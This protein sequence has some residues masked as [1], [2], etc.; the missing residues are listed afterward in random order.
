NAGQLA[1]RR[2]LTGEVLA[3]VL[4]D[5]AAALAAG[6]IGPGQVRVITEAMTAIPASV[7][8]E[9][10]DAAEADLARHA[11]SFNPTSLHKIGLRILGC[12]DPDG[13]PPR[14]E[15]Q[16]DPAAGELRLWEPRWAP[17]VG[18]LPRTRPPCRGPVVDRTT[19]R[20]PTR[21]R[22]HPRPTHLPAT[23]RRRAAGRCV[24]WPALPRTAPAPLGSL[25][26]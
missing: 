22:G 11:R 24:G 9:D 21:Y 10:R 4:P 16:P 1:S 20:T 6:E 26:I 14:D 25:R 17:G 7:S 12:L 2:T 23:Q 8:A 19:H 5:T 13:R 18:G 15:P 3:P